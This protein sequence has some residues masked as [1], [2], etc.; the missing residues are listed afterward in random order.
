MVWEKGVCVCVCV[1]G[2]R[3]AVEMGSKKT[4]LDGCPVHATLCRT[5]LA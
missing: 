2:R 1:A 4:A 3:H 5:Q